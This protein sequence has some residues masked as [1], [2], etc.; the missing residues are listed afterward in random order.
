MA[1]RDRKKVDAKHPQARAAGVSGAHFD[2]GGRMIGGKTATQSIDETTGKVMPAGTAVTPAQMPA[3]PM[4]S[5]LEVKT[6]SLD[7]FKASNT[8]PKYGSDFVGPRPE[9]TPRQKELSAAR[10]AQSNKEA[11]WRGRVPGASPADR[12]AWSQ[13]VADSKARMTTPISNP[14][15]DLARARNKP[16]NRRT[17][18]NIAA[19]T[20]LKRTGTIAVDP[21][22]AG[23]GQL[24][25]QNV[26]EGTSPGQRREPMAGEKFVQGAGI[27]KDP[28]FKVSTVAEAAQKAVPAKAFAG[29][30]SF[31][32]M[33]A[34]R[35]ATAAPRMPTPAPRAPAVAKVATGTPRAASAVWPPKTNAMDRVAKGLFGGA[36]FAPVK[37][38]RIVAQ[39]RKG[40]S[41]PTPDVGTRAQD[42]RDKPASPFVL[43]PNRKRTLASAY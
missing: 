28:A 5:N 42:R 36:A 7:A 31:D 40:L 32:V 18:Q 4:E 19:P 35:E 9:Q 15:V 17:A 10:D 2:T 21:R 37:P 41:K 38:G 33:K 29:A 1:E 6:P 11:A 26:A 12:S 22:Y 34:S 24:T 23:P 14:A 27:V 30:P 39:V 16:E 8:S 20:N 13:T 43:I 3:R 25:S